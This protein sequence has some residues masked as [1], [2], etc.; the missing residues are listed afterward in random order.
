MTHLEWVLFFSA[1][2]DGLG[3]PAQIALAMW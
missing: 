3:S 1:F 2:V